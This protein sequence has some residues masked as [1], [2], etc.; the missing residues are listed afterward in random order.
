MESLPPTRLGRTAVH[1]SDIATIA[2][3]MAATATAILA[4]NRMLR[5]RNA[6][7]P[8]PDSEGSTT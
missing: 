8:G 5:E 7:T 1:V 2:E 6:T 4:L 3:R